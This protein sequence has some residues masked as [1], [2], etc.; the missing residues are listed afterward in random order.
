MSVAVPAVVSEA[1]WHPAQMRLEQNRAMASHNGKRPYPLRGLV[2]CG[3]C[4]SHM[5]GAYRKDVRIQT[6]P[7]SILAVKCTACTGW[8]VAHSVQ[9]LF[10]SKRPLW[11]I[12][13]GTRWQGLLRQP[14]LLRQEL[15]RRREDG[16]PRRAALDVELQTVRQRLDDVPTEMDRLVDGYGKGSIPDVLMEGR[17]TSLRE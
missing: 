10:R 5:A 8:T 13:C 9:P 17:M 12:R 7:G 11:R 14:D 1:V 6:R 4:G 2:I 15:H 16:S 3:S